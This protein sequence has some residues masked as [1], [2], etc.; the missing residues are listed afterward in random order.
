MRLRS[1]VLCLSFLLTSSCREASDLFA[2]GGALKHEY[3]DSQLSVSLTDGLILTVT[4]ADS[5]L[6]VGSCESQAAMATRIASFVRGNY[7][8]FNSLQTV[9]IAFTSRPRQGRTTTGAAG[10]PFRF[11]RTLL[12]AGVTR[13]DSTRAV[14]SC[15]AWRELQ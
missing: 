1:S 8:G 9:S 12:N 15:K 14:E 7:G 2:L 13:A 4:V 10:L 6:A 5:A 11:A 3:P